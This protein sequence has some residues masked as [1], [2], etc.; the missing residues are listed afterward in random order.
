[1]RVHFII[2]RDE[3]ATPKPDRATLDR[4][5]EAI[6]RSWTDDIE[7]ALAAAHEPK[8]ARALLARYRD[9]FPIDYREVYPPATAIADIGRSRH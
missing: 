6:V 4:A 1:M 2:A 5:V 3:G 8:Q 7:E 9:A